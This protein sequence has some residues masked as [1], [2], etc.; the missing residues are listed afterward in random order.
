MYTESLLEKGYD[1]LYL[2]KDKDKLTSHGLLI[3]YKN[4]LFTQLDY[5]EVFYDV[6]SEFNSPHVITQTGNVAQLL[7]LQFKKIPEKRIIITNTHLYWR[8]SAYSIK[9]KQA[10][11]LLEKLEEMVSKQECPA[12]LCGGNF[13]LV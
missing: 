12:V 8:P 6:L 13:I 4:E 9:I 2:R 7:C 11:M 5:Q 1:Y 3:L 10:F